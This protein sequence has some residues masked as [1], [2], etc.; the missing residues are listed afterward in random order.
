[1]SRPD[2]KIILLQ[3]RKPGD[4]MAAHERSCFAESLG[5]PEE[6]I[7]PVDLLRG[8]PTRAML[9]ESDFVFVGGSGDFSV[10]DDEPFIYRF[11]DFLGDMV[12]G[13]EVPMF[14]SCFG[15]Q[16]LV[17]AGGGLVVHDPDNSEVGSFR[18]DVNAAGAEDP[19]MAELAPSFWAQEG[20][21]DRAER[22][23]AGMLNLARSERVPFQVIR[24]EGAP[25]FAT[26]FHPELSMEANQERYMRYVGGYSAEAVHG[27]EVLDSLRPTPQATALLTRWM[28]EIEANR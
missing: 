8:V 3:A 20:H 27:D 17:L 22:L 13:A 28:D 11:L 5:I 14:G 9:Q 10:L 18:V 24:V 19:L 25:I 1:M 2:P 12:S 6:H 21:K 16:A 4:E 26:Q 7:H 15:F 23:P